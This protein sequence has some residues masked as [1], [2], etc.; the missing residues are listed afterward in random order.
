MRVQQFLTEQHVPFEALIHAPAFTAQ[1]RAHFLHVPGKRLAKC[2]LLAYPGGHVLAVLPASCQVDL[3]TVSLALGKPMRLADAAEIADLF[4]DCEWGVLSPFGTLYGLPTILDDSFDAD[5]Q[6]VFES[7][8]H[9][10][11]LKMRC[12]D[13]EQLEK[14]LR[15]HFTRSRARSEMRPCCA[16]G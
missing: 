14:P 10:V 9:A 12:R 5:A 4:R 8:M 3:Q 13:F 11:T 7:E 2:V 6:I 16:A 15:L 1:K